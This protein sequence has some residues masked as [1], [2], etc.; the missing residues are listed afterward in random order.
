MVASQHDFA[1]MG[2]LTGD[3][4]QQQ[5]DEAWVQQANKRGCLFHVSL[6]NLRMATGKRIG[7]GAWPT[8]RTPLL[9]VLIRFWLGSDGAVGCGI[10]QSEPCCQTNGW[11]NAFPSWNSGRRWERRKETGVRE[12]L[13]SSHYQALSSAAPSTL[14]RL[15]LRFDCTSAFVH[16]QFSV[17]ANR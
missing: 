2:C 13:A 16:P 8:A 7:F 11:T 1:E 4:S 3:M 10:Q 15:P 17:Y 9:A 12:L 14:G 5:L 6:P